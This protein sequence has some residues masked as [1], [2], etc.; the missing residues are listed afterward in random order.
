MSMPS[1]CI[2]RIPVKK[3]RRQ[4]K[5]LL[6]CFAWQKKVEAITRCLAG[7][8]GLDLE[9]PQTPRPVRLLEANLLLLSHCSLGPA[10]RALGSFKH[11]CYLRLCFVSP[12]R[13]KPQSLKPQALMRRN[14]SS[15]V[16]LHF[17]PT[18]LSQSLFHW[19]LHLVPQFV[20][21]QRTGPV[22]K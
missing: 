4:R 18:I 3:L 15:S 14:R 22:F 6:A 19:P 20:N 13:F 9:F 21:F 5:R 12:K 11:I 17:S 2:A 1:E 8:S 10:K 16:T 7:I